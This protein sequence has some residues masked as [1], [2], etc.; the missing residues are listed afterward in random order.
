MYNRRPRPGDGEDDLLNFQQQFL[1]SGSEPSAKVIKCY[2]KENVDNKEL[3]EAFT[4]NNLTAKDDGIIPQSLKQKLKPL[5]S[6][7]WSRLNEKKDSIAVNDNGRL[8]V[9]SNCTSLLSVGSS[10]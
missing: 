3:K 4:S 2:K 6:R 7:K 9:D 8:P 1:A 5:H 10:V